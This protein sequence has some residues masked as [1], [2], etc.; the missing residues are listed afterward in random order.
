MVMVIVSVREK[1][2]ILVNRSRD[3][4]SASNNMVRRMYIKVIS[5][6][7]IAIDISEKTFRN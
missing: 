2:G 3:G 1:E 7:S 4:S 5:R 6:K